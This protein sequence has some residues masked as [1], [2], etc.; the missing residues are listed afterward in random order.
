ME[1]QGLVTFQGQPLTL[2]GTGVH[3]GDA[4][5][6][7]T[8]LNTE[9][10][11][12][13]LEHFMGQGVIISS[14]PSLDTPVCALQTKRFN[15][16]APALGAVILTISMDLPFAQKRFCEACLV[17]RRPMRVAVFRSMQFSCVERNFIYMSCQSLSA[18]M[19][20]FFIA[21]PHVL[22][23]VCSSHFILRMRTS[24]VV[25]LSNSTIA[26]VSVSP[27]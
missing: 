8:V 5:P 20:F 18:L 27:K 12:V 23:P 11:P 6:N 4:A 14:V 9:L 19:P 10:K 15:Q 26:D 3:V 1:R 16:E 21:I 17:R 2:T 22:T 25:F 13:S 7:F 24:I